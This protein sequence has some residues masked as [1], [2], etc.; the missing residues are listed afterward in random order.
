[1]LAPRLR[2]LPGERRF[3]AALGLLVLAA[4][5]LLAAWQRSSYA[6]LLGHEQLASQH[7]PGLLRPAAFLLSWLLMTVAMMLPASLPQLRSAAP[8]VILRPRP[9]GPKDLASAALSAVP[10]APAA[11]IH[12]AATALT[13]LGYLAPWALFGLLAF[14]GDTL[15]HELAEAGGPLATRAALIAPSI[16]LAAGLYQLTPAK[17]R[18]MELCHPGRHPGRHPAHTSHGPAPAGGAGAAGALP[19]GLRLGLDCLGSCGPLML[20]MFALGHSR[21][22]WMLALGALMA[23]ERLSPWGRRLALLAGLA[24]IAWAAVWLL[25]ALG[26]GPALA[27]HTH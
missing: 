9:S 4:W 2:I 16:V 12:S 6:E 26:A 20:L 3:Y 1:M 11:A 15:L 7:L 18:F 10:Q 8:G 23:A 25:A 22:D 17:R 13:L 21:L 27:A 5:A 19:Q 14:L 24:L